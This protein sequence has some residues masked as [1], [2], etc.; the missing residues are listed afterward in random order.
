MNKL[1]KK[2]QKN[3]PFAATIDVFQKSLSEMLTSDRINQQ[4]MKIGIIGTGWVSDLHLN[5]LKKIEGAEVVAIA[6][7]N[8]ARASELAQPWGAKTYEKPLSML[9]NESLDAVFILLPP[10][11][12]GDLERMCSEHVRAVLIE[13]PISQSLETTREINGYFKKA[14]TIVSVG[15]MNRYRQSV[16]K[17]HE[18]FSQP[19]NQGILA[20]GWWTTQMPP[21]LWWRTFD[22]SGGQFAEQCTHLV[23]ICRYAMGDIVE[24]SAF[25]TGGFMKEVPDYSVDDAMVV[26]ARFAS[27][28]LAS[29]STGCFPHHDNSANPDGGI[30]LSLSSRNHRIALATWNLEGTVYSGE[31]DKESIPTEEDIF[32]V[33]NK[34]FLDAAA[35]ND[36]SGILSPYE[37]AMKT[38]ATTLAANESA[39]HQNGAPVKVAH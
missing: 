38:L 39:R 12:H 19:N 27:G 31:D 1:A 8:E 20:N 14:G 23:D 10:H 29:F 13:K 16:Q 35:T 36:P 22:H 26:N 28:A 5:A 37:D 4:H 9:E 18:L 17:A 7:R 15:Y 33:Q 24:V 6:G 30:G 2:G 11:L 32:Y 34:A 21:P 25:A 3:A